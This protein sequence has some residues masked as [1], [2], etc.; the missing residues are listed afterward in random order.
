MNAGPDA[1]WTRL[2]EACS[3]EGFKRLPRSLELSFRV[4]QPGGSPAP[5]VTPL[6]PSWPCLVRSRVECLQ[7]T[8]AQ[9]LA[10]MDA[11]ELVIDGEACAHCADGLPDFHGLRSDS[12]GASACLFAFDLLRVDGLDLRPLSLEERRARLRTTLRRARLSLRVV[13]HLEATA[14]PSSATFV[15]GAGGHHLHGRDARYRSGRSLTWLKSEPELRATM[16]EVRCLRCRHWRSDD[17]EAVERE[18]QKLRDGELRRMRTGRH[19]T[20][21]RSWGGCARVDG[22]PLLAGSSGKRCGMADLERQRRQGRLGVAEFAGGL[23]DEQRI[24]FLLRHRHEDRVRRGDLAG[25]V[26]DPVQRVDRG[27]ARFGDHFG[28]DRLFSLRLRCRSS[29]S[30]SCHS[31]G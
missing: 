27:N 10:A 29:L 8:I 5:T 30:G 4:N 20:N 11:D 19:S 16:T 26:D 15:P 25:P 7:M 18:S 12:G 17:P 2:T 6:V 28:A 1:A 14:R 22:K 23:V 24:A 3:V 13:E 9:A 31:E 21:S